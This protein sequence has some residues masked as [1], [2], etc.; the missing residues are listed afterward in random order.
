M[1]G[2]GHLVHGGGDLSYLVGLLAHS[3]AGLH[4]DRGGFLCCGR[5]LAAG[6]GDLTDGLLEAFGHAVKGLAD[7]AKLVLAAIIGAGGEIPLCELIA[8]VFEARNGCTDAGNNAPRQQREHSDRQQGSDGCKYQ[9]VSI[10]GSGRLVLLLGYLQLQVEHSVK[11]TFQ[12]AAIR[13]QCAEQGLVGF[14][15]ALLL[16]LG[17]SGVDTL[18]EQVV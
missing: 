9:I 5:Q 11:G 18:Y 14:G 15:K 8:G 3:T 7:A 16:Q 2:S 1:N 17:D 6:T 13:L 10:S 4:A 12:C